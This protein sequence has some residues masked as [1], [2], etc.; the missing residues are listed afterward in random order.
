MKTEEIEKNTEQE[1]IDLLKNG[2]PDPYDVCPTYESKDFLLRFVTMDDAEDLLECYGNAEARKYFNADGCTSD[3]CFSDLAELQ[4]CIRLWLSEYQRRKFVRFSIVHKL[5]DKVVG[6]IEI[7][8][9]KHGV[10]RIDILP[11][12]ENEGHL[13]QLLDIA[14]DF[15]RDFKCDR[16]VTKAIPEAQRRITAL[17]QKGYILYPANDEWARDDYYMKRS[18]G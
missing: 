16:I 6:T 1:V 10:L 14:E 7:F 3:F 5:R 2:K 15:F 11:E 17:T 12:Y 4:A 8:G 9:G 13:T 18:Q